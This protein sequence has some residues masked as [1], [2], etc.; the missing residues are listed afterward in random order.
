MNRV[1]L[2]KL[3]LGA[4]PKDIL[5]IVVGYGI[6]QTGACCRDGKLESFDFQFESLA[7]AKKYEGK[8]QQS[9]YGNTLRGIVQVT[10]WDELEADLQGIIDSAEYEMTDEEIGNI[11]KKIAGYQLQEMANKYL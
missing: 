9:G 2:K 5:T 8:T 10:I 11:A 4:I 1:E 6:N 7:D 3:I